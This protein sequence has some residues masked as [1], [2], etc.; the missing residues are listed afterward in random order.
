MIHE[1]A[2]LYFG[3]SV[4]APSPSWYNEGMATFFE[5]FQWDGQ[6]L[7]LNNLARYR[8]SF[9]QSSMRRDDFL[10]LTEL[11]GGDAHGSINK[12]AREA[13][14]F[15]AEA[16]G[17]Y[18]F[19]NKTTDEDLKTKWAAWVDKIKARSLGWDS[20]QGT[21]AVEAFQEIFG[22]VGALQ[23]KWKAFILDLRAP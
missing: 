2:H 22:D 7:S 3:V 14:L 19:M 9:L 4:R 15:Y 1:G 12:G 21:K 8:F 16:W 13:G 10:P 18:Y 17:F 11:L 20:M 5:G 6:K 23:E